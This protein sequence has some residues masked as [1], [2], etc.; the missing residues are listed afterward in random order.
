MAGAHAT[1][2]TAHTAA[3]GDFFCFPYCLFLSPS[4]GIF[5]I[6]EHHNDQ[7]YAPSTIPYSPRN[8][9]PVFFGWF[10]VGDVDELPKADDLCLKWAR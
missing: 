10:R 8:I 3:A 9:R 6:L 7:N 4:G 2:K 1:L 5:F